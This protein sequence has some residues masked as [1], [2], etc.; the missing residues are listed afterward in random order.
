[1]NL[2]AVM[3]GSGIVPPVR[4]HKGPAA[5]AGSSSSRDSSRAG[6]DSPKLMGVVRDDKALPKLL[7]QEGAPA[8][9]RPATLLPKAAAQ[10]AG[11]SS[12]NGGPTAAAGG[13]ATAMAAGTAATGGGATSAAADAGSSA[14]AAAASSGVQQQQGQQQQGQQQQQQQQR[15]RPGPG[16]RAPAEQD[17]AWDEW[18]QILAPWRVSW[19]MLPGGGQS[20]LCISAV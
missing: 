2:A 3:R 15:P 16:A 9:P 13:T 19:G 7:G 5:A 14:A 12:S 1:M 18:S 17:M 10:T 4:L 8:P 20:M 6:R 11:S